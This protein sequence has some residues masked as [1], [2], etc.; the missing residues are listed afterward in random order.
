MENLGPVQ[1]SLKEKL[2]DHWNTRSEILSPKPQAANMIGK[3]FSSIF[4]TVLTV[5]L[6]CVILP[7]L[8]LDNGVCVQL[9]TWL[10]FLEVAWNWVLCCLDRSHATKE[11]VPQRSL[12]VYHEQ[13]LPDGWRYCPL[14]QLDAPPRSH[15]C[16]I[17]Q[18]CILKRDHHCFFTGTCIGFTNHRRFIVFV[19]YC[20]LG[21]LHATWLILLYLNKSQK[22]WPSHFFNYLPVVS[23][24]TLLFGDM[25]FGLF[26]LLL[27]LYASCTIFFISL[28]FF[29][30]ESCMV[31]RGQTSHETAHGINRYRCGLL[32]GFRS[33]FGSYG[34][35]HFLLPIN[36]PPKG[37]GYNWPIYKYCKSH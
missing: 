30:W 26:F 28:G 8:D 21:S 19:F 17:C 14:C 25:S 35:I 2:H 33:T 15:H 5:T 4:S 36:L 24:F 10:L 12:S 11:N 18:L 37:D 20:L 7:K 31:L 6:S 9:V 16:K 22:A 29:L 27:E 32:D 3:L 13:P 1:R 23:L 34:L